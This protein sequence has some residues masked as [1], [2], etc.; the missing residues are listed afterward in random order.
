MAR[1]RNKPRQVWQIYRHNAAKRRLCFDLT[2]DEVAR[3]VRSPC[4]FCGNVPLDT[5]RNGIDRVDSTLGYFRN[6]VQPCCKTCN[7]MKQR[8]EDRE[9]LNHICRIYHW[10]GGLVDNYEECA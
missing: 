5:Q 1:K 8:L 6:N 7:R 10:S 3:L 2:I 9:F 4:V